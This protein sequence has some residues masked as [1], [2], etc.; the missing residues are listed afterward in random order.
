MRLAS[1][2]DAEVHLIGGRDGCR[3]VPVDRGPAAGRTRS[4]ASAA[5]AQ[6][7]PSGGRGAA[8]AWRSGMLVALDQNGL[9]WDN[10][11]LGATT[12]RRHGDRCGPRGGDAPPSVDVV[13]AVRDRR[14]G[15]AGG[16]QAPPIVIGLGVDSVRTDSIASMVHPGGRVT[17]LALRPEGDVK[18]LQLLASR[19]P[20][21]VGSG[22]CALGASTG[23]CGRAAADAAA[24]SPSS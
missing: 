11:A 16:T 22:D 1:A 14:A 18:S 17:G 4:G 20:D 7:R 9:C 21:A 12:I 6:W 24:G 15:D 19:C 8:I 13:V 3:R 23:T 10:S 2:R 5:P